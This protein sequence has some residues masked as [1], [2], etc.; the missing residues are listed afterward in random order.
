MIYLAT[1]YT[2]ASAAVM[3]DRYELALQ[4]TYWMTITQ[5]EPVYSPIVHYHNIAVKHDLPRDAEWWKQTNLTHLR[6]CR[7]LAVLVCAGTKESKGCFEEYEFAQY[8]M[9]P[10]QFVNIRGEEVSCPWH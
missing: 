6:A 5:P 4:C 3:Q 1:P 10:V 9:M 2:H 8:L 7:A